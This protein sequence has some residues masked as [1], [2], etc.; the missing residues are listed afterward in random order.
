MSNNFLGQRKLPNRFCVEFDTFRRL[1]LKE[2]LCVMAGFN[3]VA[4]VK[5]MIDKRD[6][7]SWTNCEVGFT[8]LKTDKEVISELQ[9]MD[10]QQM[11]EEVK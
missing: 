11:P 7:R 3:I 1:S 2:R 9:K 8:P 5:V 4:R 6:G 10:M